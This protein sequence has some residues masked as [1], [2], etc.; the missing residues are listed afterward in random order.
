MA[1]SQMEHELW[2]KRKLFFQSKAS[3]VIFFKLSKFL[4]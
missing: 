3:N 2:I 4:D 1:P